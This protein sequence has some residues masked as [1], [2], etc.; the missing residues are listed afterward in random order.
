MRR[1]QTLGPALVVLSVGVFTLWAG[2]RAV[3]T[4]EHAHQMQIVQAAEV[5][6][7]GNDVL[8]QLNEAHHDVAQIVG[9]SVVYIDVRGEGGRRGGTMASGSGWVYD[10][11]GHIL[12]NNH[13]VEGAE[14]IQVQF[15]NGWVSDATLVG[16]DPSS[17]I[18]V[19]RAASG[20]FIAAKRE[21]E[22]P[23]LQG[24]QVFAFGAPYGFKFSM[25]K[26]IVSGT[27]RTAIT[28]GM[29][30]AYQNYIQ[31]DAAINPGNSG[32]PLVDIHGRV[33]GMN[34]AIATDGPGGSS[35]GVGFAIPVQAIEAI[36]G[37][38]IE[39]GDVSR[40]VMGV[41]IAPTPSLTQL[42]IWQDAGFEGRGVQVTRVYPGYAA[43]RGGLEDNDIITHVNGEE[44]SS[45]DVLRSTITS[46]RPGEVV[47][48]R[49]W[50]PNQGAIGGTVLDL[51]I[52]LTAVNTDRNGE[53]A[54][55]YSLPGDSP[56]EAIARDALRRYGL[57]ELRD[58]PAGGAR[59]QQ[60]VDRAWM[61]GLR[62]GQ[63]IVEVDGR[64]VANVEQL[65]RRLYETGPAAGEGV[66]ELTCVTDEGDRFTVSVTLTFRTEAEGD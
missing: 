30:T 61:N 26:G 60:S 50:R 62:R 13:V 43:A 33:I 24:H 39:R 42:R 1:F 41:E 58:D 56:Q 11:G 22:E 66:I 16:A 34:V 29:G 64:D 44:M 63:T 3:R 9:P 40:T 35:R 55:V 19:L 65:L 45:R 14:R 25:S 20:P 31:T 57:R 36:A 54:L 21:A 46:R 47:T 53:P 51:A 7:A 2:P 28:P 52:G 12:T 4:L 38:I 49:V 5:N 8:D 6:L 27:G 48:L 32:G 23:I 37:Q 18:A 10:D 17:D 15:A 59:I